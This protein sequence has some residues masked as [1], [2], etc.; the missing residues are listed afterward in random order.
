MT[1][2]ER[3]LRRLLEPHERRITSLVS[4]AVVTLVDEAQGLQR[5]QFRGRQG[6][7]RGPVEHFQPYGLAFR[8]LLGA[9]AIV[10]KLAGFSV[11]IAVSDR[12][13][14]P[15]DLAPGEVCLHDDHGSR[16]WIQRDGN[17]RIRGSAMV[18]V[19]A[20]SA[21][22]TGDLTVGGSITASGDVSDTAGSMAAMRAAYNPHTHEVTS[23]PGTTGTP[24][25]A[26]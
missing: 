24:S 13:H 21:E 6:E 1:G 2:L 4:R 12:R 8:P 25:G 7:P 5:I 16:V 19:E 22:I 15:R 11:V 18:T 26:M 3:T 20:P 14:R 9:E 10:L 23:A 17:I